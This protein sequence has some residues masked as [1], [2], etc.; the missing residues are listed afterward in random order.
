ML[1]AGPASWW[2]DR[3]FIYSLEIC[4]IQKIIMQDSRPH[5]QRTLSVGIM[6][7][8][9]AHNYGAILQAYALYHHLQQALSL[10]VRLVDFTT[11]RQKRVNNI[12]FKIQMG[13][14]LLKCL[15]L[16]IL[17]LRYCGRLN[18]RK[19][20][21][22]QFA[23]EEFLF[24]RLYRDLDDLRSN[25]PEFDVVITG[26][27]Q[28][29]NYRIL[30]EQE[31]QA[32]CLIP[33]SSEKTRKIAFAPSFGN[34]SIPPEVQGKMTSSLADFQCLS[35]RE[36]EGAALMEGM[37]GRHAEVLFD[38]V[39]LLEAGTWRKLM[40]PVEKI[41]PTYILCY[42]LNGRQSL[43]EIAAKIKT[44]TG[45]PIVLVTSNVR[46]GIKADRY[47]YDAGPREF[48][49]LIDNARYVVTDSFHGTAFAN[50]FERVFCSQVIMQQSAQRIVGLLQSLGQE[51]RLIVQAED[52]T[53]ENLEM[54]FTYV[55][56]VIQE[57]RLRSSVFLRG[58][59][60]T[61]GA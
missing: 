9:W 51:S 4:C 11:E 47:V 22:I 30:P 60:L 19:S 5:N 10:D 44:L 31:L 6:T 23:R 38:P 57:E 18:Q 27:D 29:F 12:Y 28:V 21:F 40:R 2:L 7:F 55:S 3:T 13:K 45:L 61:R 56:H 33:F 48:L 1:E 26:S 39:F 34:N 41:P 24:T 14:Q 43:G 15:G 17:K 8:H 37:T 20:G 58:A 32:Y 35:S 36:R 46:T 54:D 50:L 49:W 59:V 25:P 52:I 42:A 53:P 16:S